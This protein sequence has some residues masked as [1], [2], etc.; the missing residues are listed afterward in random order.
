MMS[1]N[2]D[3]KREQFIMVSMDE[4]VPQNHLLRKIDKAFLQRQNRCG[5]CGLG[6]FPGLLYIFTQ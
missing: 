6:R 2:L 5:Y 4:M 1:Q 3:K